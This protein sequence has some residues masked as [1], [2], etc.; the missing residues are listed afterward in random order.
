MEITNFRKM[1]AVVLFSFGLIS[2]IFG[3]IN[4]F[5]HN[6]GISLGKGSD[7]IENRLHLKDNYEKV[8]NKI[9]K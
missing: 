9:F 6:N 7:L 2:N 1:M 5:I 3:L 4:A 8:L